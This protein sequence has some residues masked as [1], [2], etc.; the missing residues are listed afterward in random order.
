MSG[1]QGREREKELDR[2]KEE[3]NT[4]HILYIHIYKRGKERNRYRKEDGA[5]SPDKL[6]TF[7]PPCLSGYANY[8]GCKKIAFYLRLRVQS[9]AMG[10]GFFDTRRPRRP[11]TRSLSFSLSIFLLR[12]PRHRNLFLYFMGQE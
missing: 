9:S 4:R 3:Y 5:R 8:R 11:S 10:N 7:S 1:S 2:K 12:A 6:I